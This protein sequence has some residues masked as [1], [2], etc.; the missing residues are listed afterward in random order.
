MI[1][2]RFLIFLL[3][4]SADIVQEHGHGGLCIVFQGVFAVADAPVVHQRP[5]A[6]GIELRDLIDREIRPQLSFLLPFPDD[7]PPDPPQLGQS[8]PDDSLDLVEIEL[9]IL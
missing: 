7:L 6:E 5:F 9:S 3:S 4:L 1:S 2:E 8:L